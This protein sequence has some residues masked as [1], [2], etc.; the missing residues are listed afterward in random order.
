M[1]IDLPQNQDINLRPFAWRIRILR[2]WRLAALGG[3]IGAIAG[4]VALGLDRANLIDVKLWEVGALVAAGIAVGIVKALSER[5]SASQIARS[6]DRRSDMEDRLTT[7]YEEDAASNSFLS[8]VKS[9]A[10]SHAL[11]LSPSRLYPFRFYPEHSVFLILAA[12]CVGLYI[13]FDTTIL[14]PFEERAAAAGLI[15]TAVQVR[16][17]AKPILDEAKQPE[18]TKEDKQLA[19]DIQ[20]FVRDLEKSRMNKQQALMRANQLAEQA[21]K[22]DTAK[23]SSLA[24]A[25]ASAQSA[26]DKVQQLEQQGALQK[27]DEAKLASQA[28]D[29]QKKLDELQKNLSAAKNGKSSFSKAQIQAMKKQ[30]DALN[31]QLS[32][33]KLSQQAMETFAKLAANPDYQEAQRLLEKLQNSSNLGW[34]LQSKQQPISPEQMKAMAKRLEE[35]AKKLNSD[36][37]LKEYAKA[38][39]EAAKR[40]KSVGHCNNCALG[41]PGAFG[42]PC[43]CDHPGASPGSPMPWTGPY[44]HLY[45]SDKSSLLNVKYQDR[46]ITSQIGKEGD[47]AYEEQIGPAHLNKRSSIPY[48]EMLPKYEKSAENALDKHPVPAEMRS[49][50]KDYFN[51]LR[52]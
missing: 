24:S 30:M 44:G 2:A 27:T 34:N 33:I 45:R 26:G 39:L 35:L 50:V 40:A 11:S 16:E 52:Q 18:A 9:D 46:V 41:I 7:V 5:F 22:L 13:L 31:K 38:L 21:E 29:V 19:R 43:H 6:I 32:Q 14:R 47:A 10:A 8:A 17:I 15:N 25:L 48:E 23:R 28:A 12:L 4:S 20:S 36:Q 1:A 37:K 51:S 49:Q 42:L 3:G